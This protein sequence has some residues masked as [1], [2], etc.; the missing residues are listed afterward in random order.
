M[1]ST[2]QG[3]HWRRIIPIL[4]CC[5]AGV[6]EPIASIAQAAE[7]VVSITSEPDHKIRFDNGRVRMY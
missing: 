7:V 3:N 1:L 5:Y 4:V 2:A 6:L